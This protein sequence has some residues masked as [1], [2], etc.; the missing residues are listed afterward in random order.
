MVGRAR[1]AAAK[2]V[3]YAKE[4]A[5]SDDDI[6]EDDDEKPVATTKRRGRPRKSL[7]L[8]TAADMDDMDDDYPSKPAFTEKG[9]DPTLPPI[10]ERFPFMPEYELD[11]SPRIELIVGRRPVDDKNAETS[12]EDN[13][14]S[15]E[16]SEDSE[17]DGARKKRSRKKPAKKVKK[18]QKK[19]SPSKTKDLHQNEHVEYEYLVKYKGRSYLHLEWKTGADLESMNKSAK[20]LYR[21]YLKK[22]AAGL[23]EDIEDPNFDPSFA[24]PQKIVDEDEQEIML[25]LTD[26]ELVEWEKERQKA[27]AEEEAEAEADGLAIEGVEGD[28]EEEETSPAKEESKDEK[29]E[30]ATGM[31]VMITLNVS[32]LAESTVSLSSLLI[33]GFYRRDRSS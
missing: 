4:Q 20:T 33:F 27:L 31:F 10:R 18:A 1:R 28:E 30:D 5:F 26:K 22:V 6:F 2:A 19:A 29:D 24:E 9:Y 15:N 7:D 8:M 21:R 13:D 32:M 16:E 14:A 3:D 11:G 12:D 23:D 25:E 17:E